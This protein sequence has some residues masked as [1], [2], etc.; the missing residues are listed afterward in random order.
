MLKLYGSTTSPFVR[1]LRLWL[2]NVE[3]EFINMQIFS[4]PDRELLASMNP[5][6]KIP[7][8]EDDGKVIYDS[9]VIFRYLS[10][11]FS[12]KALSWQQENLLTLIDSANDSLVQSLILKRSD[13]E[14]DNSKLIFRLQNERVQTILE[15]LNRLVEE[16]EFSNWHY[17]EICLYCLVDWIEF[18]ELHDLSA[19]P[20]LLEF[21]ARH[22]D[23]IEVTTTNPRNPD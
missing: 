19:M 1:R 18:R 4:G 15:H 20:A 10:D 22:N 13:I 16:G 2:A 17:P 11:K 21:Q 3:H 12:E 9:R 14:E 6:L 8:I 5:T 7:M 23:R